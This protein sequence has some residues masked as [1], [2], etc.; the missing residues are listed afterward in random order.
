[1]KIIHLFW[2]GARELS[3]SWLLATCGSLF[4]SWFRLLF[5]FFRCH[6]LR[7]SFWLCLLFW[8]WS[9][10]GFNISIINLILRVVLIV[11]IINMTTPSTIRH[12]YVTFF[13]DD[14]QAFFLIEHLESGIWA[15]RFRLR[16]F[17][18]VASVAG[19]GQRWPSRW[20]LQLWAQLR[21]VSVSS[22]VHS[23][24]PFAYNL[25]TTKK[26][27]RKEKKYE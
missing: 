25:K 9:I 21:I 8:R 5:R 6:F 1:M 7:S 22:W 19:V 15:F 3:S 13:T 23:F 14:L 16:L 17:L 24:A 4:S 2:A 18:S 26:A 27:W 12:G 10:L 11:V 20:Q